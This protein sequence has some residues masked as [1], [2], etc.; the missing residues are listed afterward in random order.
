[1]SCTDLFDFHMGSKI[2]H[3]EEPVTAMAKPQTPP[4][5]SFQRGRMLM[6]GAEGLLRLLCIHHLF[7]DTTVPEPLQYQSLYL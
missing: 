6:F 7:Q 5:I 4:L 1:M 2:N 3:Q